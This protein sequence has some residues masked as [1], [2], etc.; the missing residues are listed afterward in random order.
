MKK[1]VEWIDTLRGL[2]M[3]FVVLGHA[4]IDKNNVIRNY[5]YS[6]H[7]PLFFFISGLTTQRKDI[8]VIDYL[9]KKTKSILIPYIFLNIFM[10]LYKIIMNFSVGMY[11]SLNIFKSLGALFIGYGDSIPCIQSWFLL[12]LFIMDLFFFML[13]KIT[14]NDKQLTLGVTIMFIL[15]C[16]ISKTNS[17]LLLFWHIDTALVGILFYY[18]GYIFMKYIDKLNIIINNTK[19]ILLIIF[20]LPLGYYLQYLNGR[21]SMNGNNYN[22]ISLFLLS[23]LIT[24]FSLIIF[25]NIIL[26][27]DKLFKGVGVM[28]IFYLGYHSCLLTPIKHFIKPM[29]SNNILTIITSIIVFIL[30]YPIS[31]VCLKHIPILVGKFKEK[32]IRS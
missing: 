1:R 2:A 17:E 31:K 25:T 30:L 29:V 6:F 8:K 28:S 24:I 20:T 4:F 12:A 32:N 10:L 23:S 19:S 26:K 21:V 15:G 13:T 14:K 18:L 11:P 9:K 27:K 5:I 22:N 3:F 16:I 7:M